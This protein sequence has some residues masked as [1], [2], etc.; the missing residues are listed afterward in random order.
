MRKTKPKPTPHSKTP[1]RVVE[2]EGFL[3]IVSKQG[4][5]ILTITDGVPTPQERA[6]AAFIV[7]ACNSVKAKGKVPND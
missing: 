2:G 6:N 1:F 4:W 5:R 7:R 3:C